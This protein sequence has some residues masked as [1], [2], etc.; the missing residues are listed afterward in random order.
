MNSKRLKVARTSSDDTKEVPS[1]SISDLPNDLLK[2]CFSFIPGSYIT[3]AQVSRQFFSNYSTV[4]IDDSLTVLST[5]ALL[6]IGRNKRTTADAVSNDVFL[7]EYGFINNAPTEFMNEVCRKAIMKGRKDIIECATV[8]GIDFKEGVFDD[9]SFD[10]LDLMSGGVPRQITMIQTLA[11]GGNLDMLRYLF[12]KFSWLDSEAS[13][14]TAARGASEKGHLHVLQWFHEKDKDFISDHRV[15]EQVTFHGHLNILRWLA[16]DDIEHLLPLSNDQNVAALSGSVEALKFLQEKTHP[17]FDQTVF[18]AAAESGSIDMLKYCHENNC[19]FDSR[20]YHDA[21]ENKDKATVLQTLKW[22]SRHEFPWDEKVC[23]LAAKTGNLCALKFARS[24]GCPWNAEETVKFAAMSGS[25]DIL[26]YCLQN[27]CELSADL[28]TYSV[29]KENNPNALDTLQWLRQRS[30]PWDD[31]TCQYAVTYNNYDAFVWA[32]NNGCEMDSITFSMVM[33]SDNI[34]VIEHCLENQDKNRK[35]VQIR[36]RNVDSDDITSICKPIFT[37]GSD[38]TAG[39]VEKLRLLQKYGHEW[40][41][42]IT[43][44]AADSGNLQVLKW[45][46]FRGCPWDARTCNAAV[47]NNNLEMLKYAHEN[48]CKWTKNTYAHCFEY[49][50]LHYGKI[51]STK[52]IPELK[53]ILKYLEDH[54]CPRP[55]ESDWDRR[56]G[57]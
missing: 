14:M 21:F 12:G 52:P 53:N 57:V 48:G 41:A 1:A 23:E 16:D 30:C 46:H 37:L 50:G 39:L 18:A 49:M 32:R 5:D 55:E 8:F 31:K 38:S 9:D 56:Q 40:N 54:D 20:S 51:T 45:L 17:Q 34:S 6:K 43:A 44:I 15:A 25:I 13:A 19:P 36:G 47:R 24:E 10:I 42:S 7:T 4:D 35:F 28:C 11:E 26:E 33:S 27:G 29:L 22:L 2:H 3:V